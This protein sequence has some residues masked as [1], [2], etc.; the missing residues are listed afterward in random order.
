MQVGRDEN[1]RHDEVVMAAGKV[2]LWEMKMQ[3]GSL[4]WKVRIEFSSSLAALA[5]PEHGVS[6]CTNHW[7]QDTGC[8]T[9][10]RVRGKPSTL[11]DVE[12]TAVQGSQE[13]PSSPRLVASTQ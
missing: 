2:W 7:G 3:T 5:I 11:A 4:V 10:R 12:T 1:R 13:C 8:V 6:R 9:G